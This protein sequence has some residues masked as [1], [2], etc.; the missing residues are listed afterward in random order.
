MNQASSSSITIDKGVCYVMFAYD[1][2]VAINLDEADRHILS[3]K[4]RSRILR[5]RAAPQYFDY[6]PPPLRIVQDGKPVAIADRLT[7]SNVD[8]VLYD[9]GAVSVVYR[10]SLEGPFSLLLPLSEALYENAVLLEESR[11][12]VETVLNTIRPAVEK[13]GIS[14]F[15]EDYTIF[16]VEACTPVLKSGVLFPAYAQ[17]V[18]QI[19]RCEPE[20][21]SDQEISDAI[22][23][24]ISF[25]I[26]DL[27]I[28]DWNAALIFGSEMEDVRAVLEFANVELLER[29]YSDQHLD[30][31][32]DEAYE[33]IAKRSWDR[34]RWPGSY[35]ADLRRIAQLQVDSAI[36]FERVTNTLKLIG[37]QYLARVYRLASR[38]FHLEGWDASILRKLE[39]LESIY[40]KL[41]DQTSN[42]RIEILEWIIIILI[43]VSILLPFVPGMPGY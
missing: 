15:I 3:T 29:R 43:A 11:H 8:V 35:Q 5:K 21:L 13:A 28:I 41:S 14:E 27:S 24:Q 18:A 12:R 16:H 32:L 9:F 34:F 6:R 37:D 7:Q 17:K 20:P 25:G 22:S 39:T 33:A 4:E 36:L 1:I 19:L 38:R 10:I 2:G 26:E 42:R 23:S 30:A 40:G 31:A